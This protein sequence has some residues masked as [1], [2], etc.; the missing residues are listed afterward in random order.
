MKAFPKRTTVTVSPEC[1][2][3]LAVLKQEKLSKA[4]RAD[5]FRYIIGR[6]LAFERS[7]R[8]ENSETKSAHT[9]L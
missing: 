1:E 2:L 7:Q 6:G 8:L 5:M 4:S 9:E 3:S